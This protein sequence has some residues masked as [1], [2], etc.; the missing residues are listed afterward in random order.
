MGFA[1]SGQGM[2]QKQGTPPLNTFDPFGN[3][4]LA[5][6]VTFQTALASGNYYDVHAY[7][8]LNFQLLYHVIVSNATPQTTWIQ[9]RWF[10]DGGNGNLGI[11]LAQDE[12]YASDDAINGFNLDGSVFKGMRII[13]PVKGYYLQIVTQ[14]VGLGGPSI[15][16]TLVGQFSIIPVAEYYCDSAYWGVSGL[17]ARGTMW[18]RMAVLNG[19][20][21][22]GVA[23][24]FDYPPTRSG[25]ATFHALISNVTAAVFNCAVIDAITNLRLAGFAFA[26]N[27]NVAE[28]QSQLVL[29]N[30]PLGI[31]ISP[32]SAGVSTVQASLT[33]P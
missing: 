18:D 6:G 7:Q 21:A 28:S 9:F 17:Q 20:K 19:A 31:L 3:A 25:Q 2:A 23:S 24:I 12:Y 33:F 5:G 13:T 10:T 8:S 29:P 11:L 14:A 27:P 26:I 1:N 16:Y 32:T 15:T 30:R 4:A 22:A